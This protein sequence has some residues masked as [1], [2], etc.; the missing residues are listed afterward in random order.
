[1]RQRY[2]I[3]ISV[4]YLVLGAIMLVR[5]VIGHFLPIAVLGAVFIALGLVRLREYRKHTESEA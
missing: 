3:A 5:S 4:A 1:M 2:F